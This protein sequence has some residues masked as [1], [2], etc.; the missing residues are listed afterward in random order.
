MCVDVSVG[1]YVQYIS[2][3]SK[4]CVIWFISLNMTDSTLLE[5]YSDNV[6]LSLQIFPRKCNVV[7]SRVNF[8]SN[9]CFRMLVTTFLLE[10][11]RKL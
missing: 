3:L 10:I 6:Q 7:S 2:S 5:G 11:R 9:I 4:V 8:L 1:F